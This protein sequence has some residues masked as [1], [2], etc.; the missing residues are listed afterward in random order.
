MPLDIAFEEGVILFC[1]LRRVDCL[2]RSG[3]V[4]HT[5]LRAGTY[6][7]DYLTNS[8]FDLLIILPYL[9]F[10]MFSPCAPSCYLTLGLYFEVD[11]WEFHGIQRRY[12]T[13]IPIEMQGD[14]C[15]EE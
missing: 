4:Y 2:E 13:E 9:V 1:R 6:L 10:M 5:R 15:V 7:V 8:R 12:V 11:W 3:C 14:G